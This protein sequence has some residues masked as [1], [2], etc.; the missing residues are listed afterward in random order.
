MGHPLLSSAS[1][2]PEAPSQ[3]ER[4]EKQTGQAVAMALNSESR[5]SDV[6]AGI[7][8]ESGSSQQKSQNRSHCLCLPSQVSKENLTW[9]EVQPSKGKNQLETAEVPVFPQNSL[10][11]G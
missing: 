9:Q 1:L 7:Q 11:Q 3:G 8:S 6:L 4:T 5:Y 10:Q 2:L